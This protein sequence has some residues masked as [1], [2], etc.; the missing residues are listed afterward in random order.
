MRNNMVRFTLLVLAAV[1]AP[2]L[3]ARGEEADRS[4]NVVTL[5][6]AFDPRD[7]VA[8]EAFTAAKA[9]LE[10]GRPAEAVEQFRKAAAFYEQKYNKPGVRYLCAR[11]QQEMAMVSAEFALR[12]KRPEFRFVPILWASSYFWEGYVLIDLKKWSEART[13]LE[14]A[15][16]LSPRNA[17]FLSE[18]GHIHQAKKDWPAALET[19]RRAEE[20]A[21][22]SPRES[23]AEELARALRGQGYALIAMGRLDEAEK[24]LN[25]CLNLDPND[26][27]ARGA[28][29][30]IQRLREK[31]GGK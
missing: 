31:S 5:P 14:H 21:A 29:T 10:E 9:R 15:I 1:L 13:A 12:P 30:Y 22:V 28:L 4:P 3:P 2:S 11:S 25:R 6:D 18:L 19:F 23:R 17:I 16:S 24:L 7:R 20:A 26:R 27:K 8:V